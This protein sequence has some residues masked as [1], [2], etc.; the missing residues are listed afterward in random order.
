MTRAR[1]LLADDHALVRKGFRALLESLGLEVVAETG[2]GRE[3]LR[4]AEEKRPDIAFLDIAMPGMNGL[5]V[6]ARMAGDLPEVRVVIL[7]MHANEEYV[8][9]A[10]RVGAVGYLLKSADVSELEVALATVAGGQTYLSPPISR[11]LIEEYLR[12]TGEVE[13]PLDRLTPRQR[14]VLQLIAEGRT[15]QEIGLAL[16]VSPKTVETHRAQLMERLGIHDVA[17][18]VRFAIKSGLVSPES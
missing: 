5:E 9:Q 16:G 11:H 18:L 15:T 13:T 2:D 10:L 12:R 6:A 1:V 4:L 17:G 14:E 7:S 8:L 3:V